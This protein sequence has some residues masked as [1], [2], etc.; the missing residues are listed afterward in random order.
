[1]YMPT[2]HIQYI[3]LTCNIKAYLKQK[4]VSEE[5]SSVEKIA[6]LMKTRDGYHN[7]NMLEMQRQSIAL[8]MKQQSSFS[9][10]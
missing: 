8:A 7:V 4:S 9:V 5:E 6:G 10:E 1:M 3:K 2:N